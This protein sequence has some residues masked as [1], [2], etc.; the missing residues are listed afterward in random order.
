MA[1]LKTDKIESFKNISFFV[2]ECFQVEGVVYLVACLPRMHEA[3]SL[4]ASVV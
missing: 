1:E 3:L 2:E 4:I